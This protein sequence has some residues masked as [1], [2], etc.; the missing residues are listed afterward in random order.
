MQS[1]FWKVH[2]Y[3]VYVFAVGIIIQIITTVLLS[4]KRERC[5]EMCCFTG[6]AIVVR[7]PWSKL[8]LSSRAH[9]QIFHL[10][11][12]VYLN[13]QPF[14]YWPKGLTTML[15]VTNCCVDVT[16]WDAPVHFMLK[17][18][19]RTPGC[20]TVRS[21]HDISKTIWYCILPLLTLLTRLSLFLA[22]LK[23]LLLAHS[24]VPPFPSPVFSYLSYQISLPKS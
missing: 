24:T 16:N 4:H 20:L 17:C 6:S 15:P 8:G 18:W 19:G 22:E 13:Q 23:L 11:S 21:V 10:N 1:Y 3:V 14:G 9:R 12:T 5:S 2:F 7:H